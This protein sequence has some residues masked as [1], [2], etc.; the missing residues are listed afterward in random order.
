MARRYIGEMG[1]GER[2]DDQVFLI[3]S[4]DLR[5]TTQGGLYIHA[6]LADR[7]GQVPGRMWQASE[8]MFE[9]LPE[10]GFA[11]FK[12]RTEN[13]KGSL[14]FI[15]EGI[16]P[17]RTDEVELAE[18]LPRTDKDVDAMWARVTQIL[19]RIAH[20]D[21][22][23]LV[24]KFLADEELMGRFRT[25]PAAITLHH[26]YLGGLLEHTLNLLELAL[27]VIPRYPE[28]NP[29][30]MVA[31]LFLHDIGKTAEL[32]YQ[33]SFGYTDPGQLLG[34]LVQ[35]T[36]WIEE[37]C[38][39]IEADTGKPFPEP[40]KWVLQHI[41]LSHHGKHE[42]GSPK[43]PAIPEAIA[44]HHLDNLDAK[45]KMFLTEI[46]KDRDPQSNWSN[47]NRVLETKVY[48]VDVANHRPA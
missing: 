25:A 24:D 13:Y 1:P 48:K 18:F 45:V 9:T 5:T 43:L 2:I 21:L 20:P 39:L 30:L 11:R 6:V 26:S 10:G 47:Y 16:R 36:L 19:G 42:F 27:L 44:I 15:I 41:V 22:R 35:A 4:K 40:L 8:Q 3:A 17:V 14:Q 28:L 7:T 23:R 33:T 34:H 38:A 46:E 37:K 29:D 12:G 32:T 31:G